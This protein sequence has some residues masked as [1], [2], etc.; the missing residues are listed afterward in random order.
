MSWQGN[1]EATYLA[2]RDHVVV[3]QAP[4]VSSFDILRILRIPVFHVSANM[5]LAIVEK[6]NPRCGCG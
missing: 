1:K 5:I 2:E 3:M 4:R 6:I